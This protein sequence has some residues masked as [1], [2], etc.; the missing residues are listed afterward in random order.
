M[1][2]AIYFNPYICNFD[3]RKRFIGVCK[4]VFEPSLE[5]ISRMCSPCFPSI[6]LITTKEKEPRLHFKKVPVPYKFPDTILTKSGGST[7]G[8]YHATLKDS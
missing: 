3:L 5:H 6:P 1:T 8:Y 7:K 2:E 4:Y